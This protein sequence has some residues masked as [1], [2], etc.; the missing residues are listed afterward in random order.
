MRRALATVAMLVVAGCAGPA[1]TPATEPGAAP[2]PAGNVA[3]P[4]LADLNRVDFPLDHWTTT[5]DEYI[6]LD[7]ASKLAAAACAKRYGFDW[8]AGARLKLLDWKDRTN[9]LG[10]VDEDAARLAGYH[11]D[12]RKAH[13][14]SDRDNGAEITEAQSRILMGPGPDLPEGGCF[15]EGRRE[16]GWDLDDDFWFQELQAEA[17]ERAFADRRTTKLH[18]RWSACMAE[19]GHRYSK[20]EDA[21]A[22]RRWPDFDTAEA[23]KAEINAAVAD[24]RCKKRVK[25]VVELSATLTGF[26]QEIVEQNAERLRA[27]RQRTQDA[28]RKAAAV[29]GGR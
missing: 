20:P 22:D 19:S 14:T 9:R 12:P 26:Q 17:T 8:D 27:A 24:V 10:L 11:E 5:P 6:E 7:Y 4:M 21:V 16:I 15:G 2:A 23:S 1:T 13:H 3:S 18:Q 29:L 28:L 25:Y